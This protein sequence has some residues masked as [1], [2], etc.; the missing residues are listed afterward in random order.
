MCICS[1]LLSF[2]CSDG[3]RS[4]KLYL[5]DLAGSESVS[6]ESGDT[7]REGLMINQGLLQLGIVMSTLSAGQDPPYRSS[8]LTAI[9]KGLQV[10]IVILIYLA[11]FY[12]FINFYYVLSFVLTDSLSLQNF[13]VLIACVSPLSADA[14]RSVKSLQFASRVGNMKI[15][16][17][18]GI[19]IKQVFGH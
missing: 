1:F 17:E 13:I 16:P 6:D 19:L 9:L 14:N 10:S 3:L 8:A 18:A 4:S 11:C 15:N 12:C 5:V 2:A 7:R